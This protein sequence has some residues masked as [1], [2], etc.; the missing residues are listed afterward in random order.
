MMSAYDKC[1]QTLQFLN[2]V[3][4]VIPSFYARYNICLFD[5]NSEI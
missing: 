5:N 2:I 1:S 4:F 3:K